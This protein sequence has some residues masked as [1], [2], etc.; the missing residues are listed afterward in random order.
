MSTLDQG[1]TAPGTSFPGQAGSSE[2]AARPQGLTTAEADRRLA[3]DGP[4]ALPVRR[5]V[6]A[7]RRFAAELVHFFALLFWVAGG[8][9]F[10]AGMPQLGV[11]VFVV[12]VLNGVFAFAQEQRAEHAAEKLRS[13]LPRQVTVVR[14]GHTIEIPAD[15]L[16]IGDA[17][18]LSEG[19]RVSADLRL[20]RVHALAVDTSALT[21]ESVPEHP[22]TGTGVHAGCFVV[23]GEA[24]ATV[25]ATGA[26]TRLAG[27][28]NLTQSRRPAA[29]PLRRELDRLSR[30]MAAVAIGVG[31]VFFAAALLLGTPA[32]DGF[33][34]AVGV[35]VAVVP[36]G[37]L[38]TVTLSLAM[39]AQRMA[40]RHALVRHLEAVETLGSTTFICT[41]KTGTLTRNEMSVVEVWLPGGTVR[42]SGEGYQPVAEVVCTPSSS[43]AAARRLAWA[44][45]RCSSGRAVPRDGSWEAQG[46]PMEAALD[47]FAH[48]IGAEDDSAVS[49]ERARFPFDA[50]RRRM[51]IVVGERVLVKGAPDAIFSRCAPDP[52]AT[53]AL[54]RLAGRGLRV[55]A[56]A[57]RA[58]TAGLPATPEQAEQDLTLIGLVALEDPPRHGAADAIAACRRAGIRVAMITGD[59]PE[60]ARA[61]AREVGLG[62]PAD[63]VHIG[64]DL[65]GDT[66][67]LGDLL[68][69]DAV[70]VARVTPEDKLRIAEALQVRGHVVAMTGDGVNDAPAL[71]AAAIGVAMGRSGTDVAREA[72]DLVLLDD[73]FGTIVAAV[74]QGRSTYANIRRFLTYHLTDNVAEL[75]PF[76][77]W[78]LSGGGFP[79][80]IGV[81][82]VLALDI[83]TDVLP[84]LALGAEPPA[85]HVLDR[86]PARGHLLDRKLF[87]RAFGVLG[88]VEAVI[89]LSAFVLSALV[90]GWRPG[91][92]FPTGPALAAASGAAFTAIVFGQVANAFACRSTVRAFWRLPIRT[93]RLL[94]YAVL[95]ELATLATF[96]YIGPI[97]GLLGHNGP[98]LAGALIA[99]LAIPAV[100]LADTLQKHLTRS[101]A[102]DLRAERDGRS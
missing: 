68:D 47:A 60:T 57:E 100:L 74:E 59:H 9:A 71:R 17:V 23:E 27:I 38:P 3:A 89:A 69:R 25:V 26:R 51:S 70:V 34:F 12:V 56:V 78:A 79:L 92:A 43:L 32:S 41:D 52:A 84:A 35:T 81:L 48:R 44:A 28:A 77:V 31:A 88:P 83:G 76:V 66:T 53:A 21:G 33:L 85:R 96:L 30:I 73:D 55:L 87:A 94:G 80:A 45:R 18:L 29:T 24:R 91:E 95:A 6:P 99:L 97:A 49:P 4:N 13:L 5:G 46:D 63:P 50:R 36:C 22:A 2:R 20:D 19:D 102:R 82:Q 75:A 37:L 14:D 67:K 101:R 7:W 10:I 93:N 16:V 8:L 15:R 39:G 61:I 64:S 58:V 54:H 65:P 72:A 40:D 42:I 11:A 90:S 98:T 1:E 62:G 86:P